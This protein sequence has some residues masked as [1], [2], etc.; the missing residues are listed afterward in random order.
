M[1][2]LPRSARRARL[3]ATVAVVALAALL[4]LALPAAALATGHIT[5]ITPNHAIP[6]AN[7]TI[8]G[9]GFGATQGTQKV[10]FS[11]QSADP[12]IVSWSDTQIVVTVPDKADGYPYGKCYV[13]IT[14]SAGPSSNELPFTIEANGWWVYSLSPT[15]GPVG[16][17]VTVKGIRFGGS[18]PSSAGTYAPI[19]F[20]G[21][22]PAPAPLTW[23]D[24]AVTFKVP[25]GVMTGVHS[26]SLINWVH[27]VTGPPLNL[28]FWLPGYTNSIQFRVDPKVTKVAPAKAHVGATVTVSGVGFGPTKGTSKVMVGS[29][30]VAKYYSWSPTK[31]VIKVPSVAL[32]SHPIKVK[33][34]DGTSAAKAFSVY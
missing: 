30:A 4:L 15:H 29:K 24:S 20:N 12:T 34:A 14:D 28:D 2:P 9:S 3:G 7:V 11:I 26:V 13:D 31:I 6:T 17:K 5:S 21:A 8:K 27:I 22:S 19:Q 25:N 33:T 23:S 10:Y 16:T 18:V 1:K 32:G